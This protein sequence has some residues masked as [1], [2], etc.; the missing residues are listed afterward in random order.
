[1]R[2]VGIHTHIHTW[3][4][5]SLLSLDEP[6]EGV[7]H[8]C[9][10]TCCYPE[11]EQVIRCLRQYCRATRTHEIV[12]TSIR[13]YIYISFLDS[14]FSFFISEVP[15]GINNATYR[16]LESSTLPRRRGEGCPK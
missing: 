5:A 14:P 16:E 7:N 8:V 4:T 13:S 3:L 10:R 11:Q 9:I 12:H 2:P 15:L 6:G 1:M